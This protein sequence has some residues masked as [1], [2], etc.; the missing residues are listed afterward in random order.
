[1]SLLASVFVIAAIAHGISR[2]RAIPL[3]PLLLAGG[4]IAAQ[5]APSTAFASRDTALQLAMTFLMFTVGLELTPQRIQAAGRAV[6]WV[7]IA[8]FVVM[9]LVG[10][11]LAI[12]LG[13]RQWEPFYLGLAL[14]ASSTLVVI[15]YLSSRRQLF[16]PFGRLVTGVLLA[17]DVTMIAVLATLSRLSEGVGP[18]AVGFGCAVALAGTAIAVQR[19]VAPRL[20][21]QFGSCPES[22]LMAT[23][24]ILFLFLWVAD[25][26][27]LPPLVGAF[28]AG[29][30]L[31]QFPANG[32]AR[33]LLSSFADFFGAIFFVLLGTTLTLPTW[34]LFLKALSFAALVILLTPPIVTFVAEKF[35]YS[36]RAAIESGFLLA[37]VS[38][39]ALI[40]GLLGIEQGHIGQEVYSVIAAVLV[41]TTSA[42]PF[43]GD[44]R[45]TNRVM[46]MRNPWKREE[47][48]TLEGHAIMLGFGAAGAWI[49]KPLKE[50]GIEVLVVD[51]DAQVLS[52]LRDMGVRCRRGDATDLHTLQA[53]HADKALLIIATLRRPMEVLPALRFAKGVPTF[54]RVFEEPEAEIIRK[55]GGT[56]VSSSEAALE[57][58]LA[59]FDVFNR[60]RRPELDETPKAPR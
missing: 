4:F 18:G 47:S 44:I 51:D 49:Y 55:N 8:Q 39:F 34:P 20:V 54:V 43:L 48:N 11:L 7:A 6:I 33:S 32:I 41:L 59:W 56:A 2:A 37:Q 25:F 3:I 57:V 13:F 29:F 27:G 40:L 53:I 31:A 23:L 46:H 38:E 19:W 1:M 35:H 50:A 21:S 26:W 36:A 15:R 22:M 24:T 45:L 10:L 5:L 28:F 12:G 42:T 30:S 52:Q 17:Q 14:S 60:E 9:G 58:F 16:E